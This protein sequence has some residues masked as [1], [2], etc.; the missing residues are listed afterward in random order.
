MDGNEKAA[1]DGSDDWPD[2]GEQDIS[3][4]VSAN[5]SD[6]NNVTLASPAAPAIVSQASLS[7]STSTTKSS[8]LSKKKKGMQM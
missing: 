4:E 3:G 5:S 2:M 6:I 1:S 7:G 8:I